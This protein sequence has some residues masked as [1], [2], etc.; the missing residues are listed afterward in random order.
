MPGIVRDVANYHLRFSSELFGR[1]SLR[2]V[3]MQKCS[4][5]LILPDDLD[6]CSRAISSLKALHNLTLRQAQ[7]A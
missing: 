1:G 7:P 5:T 3:C 6:M 2:R 4:F